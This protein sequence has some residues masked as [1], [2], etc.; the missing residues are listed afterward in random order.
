MLPLLAPPAM[1]PL[2]AP[3]YEHKR[4]SDA[5]NLTTSAHARLA[6]DA[7]TS[8]A[9]VKLNRA[10]LTS[11]GCRCG[12]CIVYRNAANVT[13]SAAISSERH[14]RPSSLKANNAARMAATGRHPAASRPHLPAR[15][16]AAAATPEP[17]A[18][19]RMIAAN[20]SLIDA[21]AGHC[22]TLDAVGAVCWSGGAEML[23]RNGSSSA[24]AGRAPFP[25]V[26]AA[27]FARITSTA[28]KLLRMP[29]SAALPVSIS[30]SSDRKL[31][32]AGH[33][34]IVQPMDHTCR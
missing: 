10:K 8:D 2:L 15:L 19:L 3:T 11:S 30:V 34:C 33:D 24:G 16:C 7:Q 5:E 12:C 6:V 21:G 4:S 26:T 1:L 29:P 31:A 28:A 17:P 13:V 9:H 23:R 32:L 20:L 27:S 18:A 22:A 25:S 14:S